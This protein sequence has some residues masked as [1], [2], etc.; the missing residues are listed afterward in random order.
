ME[1]N[2]LGRWQMRNMVT[3]Q[4]ST[5]AMLASLD[6]AAD[7]RRRCAAALA[8]VRRDPPPPRARRMP[9][10][11]VVVPAVEAAVGSM[12]PPA[13][14]LPMEAS[15]WRFLSLLLAPLTT[16]V[17]VVTVSTQAEEAEEALTVTTV[18]VSFTLSLSSPSLSSVS[19]TM[20]WLEQEEGPF[21][22]IRGT[23]SAAWRE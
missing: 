19:A 8:R 23:P 22:A 11:A 9:P 2:I 14:L 15:E 18:G 10:V 16:V 6:C 13:L 7:S 21:T 1:M 17:M 5:S 12:S 20:S 4:T 3:V